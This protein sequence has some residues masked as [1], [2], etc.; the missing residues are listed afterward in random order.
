MI[1]STILLAGAI[2]I[3]LAIHSI[4]TMNKHSV[5]PTMTL[6]LLGFGLVFMGLTIG[7]AE[8]AGR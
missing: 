6:G 7:V 1:L 5:W 3:V 2:A 8:L 4:L